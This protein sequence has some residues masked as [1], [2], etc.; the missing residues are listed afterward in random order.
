MDRVVV[1]VRNKAIEGWTSVRI[2][3]SLKNVVGETRLSVT[4]EWNQAR[5]LIMG[6]GEPV[7]IEIGNDRVATGYITEFVPS[8][9]GKE[10]RYELVCHDKTID[11]VECSLIHPSGEWKNSTLTQITVDVCKPFG[12]DVV[13]ETRIG[14]AFSVVRVEHGET[15]FN[16]LDRLARQRGVLLTSN[17]YG[18][19]VIT[20]ASKKRL[21]VKLETGVNIRAARGRFSMQGSHSDITVKGDSGIGGEFTLAQSGNQSV[22]EKNERVKRYRPIIVLMEEPFTVVGVSLRG[23]WHIK[24]TEAQA[25]TS[26]ITVSGW[27]M[28]VDFSGELWPMNRLVRI[29]DPIQTIEDDM[30]ISGFLYSEDDSGRATVLTMAYPEAL[31]VPIEK[32]QSQGDFP[33]TP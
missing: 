16:F 3:R 7:V 17:A 15:V 22:T 12:I 11:L 9:D 6:E 33:W 14:E 30:L 32:P 26:E 18:N 25:N 24:H 21:S 13:V 19:L 5:K 28:G 29:V 1:K 20:T 27:R 4:K 10:V 23:Q 2:Q 31:E 8:Y